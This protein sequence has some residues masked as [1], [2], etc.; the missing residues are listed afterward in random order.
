MNP[1]KD[2]IEEVSRKAEKQYQ[3]EKKLKEMEETVKV[4][5]L[6]ITEYTKSKKHTHVLKGVDEIQQ[7]LD[8]QLNILTMMKVTIY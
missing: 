7:I 5:K 6:D 2:I 1:N 3:I 8:D 4:I